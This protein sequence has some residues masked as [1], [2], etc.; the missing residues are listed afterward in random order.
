[1]QRKTAPSISEGALSPEAA[2]RNPPAP[3]TSVTHTNAAGRGDSST[4]ASSQS[5]RTATSTA[6]PKTNNPS[7]KYIE[8]PATPASGIAPSIVNDRSGA[9]RT[10]TANAMYPATI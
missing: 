2:D 4:D 7:G 3:C 8:A 9:D 5:R 6:A 10:S 1:M